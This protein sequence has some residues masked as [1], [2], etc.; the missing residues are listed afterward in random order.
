MGLKSM[1]S[2]VLIGSLVGCVCALQAAPVVA[3]KKKGPAPKPPASSVDTTLLKRVPAGLEIVYC[4]RL[5]Y[6]DG[7]WYA[8]IGYY[9]TNEQDK[10]YFGNGKPDKSALYRYTV[11]TKQKKMIFDAQGGSV[12]DPTVH[13]DG[14]TILFSYRPAN[15]DYFNLYTIQSDGTGLKQITRGPWDDYEPCWLPDGDIVFVSTRCKR[16]VGCWFTQVGV[17][18]RCKPDGSKIVQLSASIEHDNTPAV[19][20]DGRILFMRWEYVDRSQVEYHALWTMNPDG[21]SVNVF[22]GNMHSWIVMID[23]QPIPGTQE[24]I[25]S[26]SPG[27]GRNEHRGVPTIVSPLQ[28]PDCLEAATKLSKSSNYHDPIPLSKDLFMMAIDR[29]IVVMDREGKECPLY[30][31]AESNVHEPRPLLPRPR[32]AVL[33]SRTADDVAAT[34][35]A[36][37]QFV[38]QN[39]YQ[40]RNMVGVKPGDIKKLLVLEVLP[41]TI[42]F[43]GGMDLTSASGSFNIERVLG[44]VPVEDDGSASFIVPA[45]RAL[46]FVALDKNDLSVKRMQSFCNVMP[47]ESFTCVGCHE[48]RNSA[49]EAKSTP[50]TLMALQRKPSRIAS[51]AGYPDVF[52][53]QRDIQP[54]LDRNCVRCHSPEK[55]AGKLDLSAG[56]F[57]GFACSYR[58]LLLRR[59]V[60]D[61]ENSVGNRA[62]RTIG[63]SAS[64]LLDYLGGKHKNVKASEKDWRTVWLW[65]ESGCLYAGSCAAIRNTTEQHYYGH[66]SSRAASGLYAVLGRRCASCHK[67][68]KEANVNGIPFNWG[69][70]RDK[71]A[72]KW[73]RKGGIHGRLTTTNDPAAL[74]D[75]MLLIN[76]T[77]PENSAVLRVPL[78]KAAGGT[79]GCG[80]AIFKDKND[81]D[82][83]KILAGI[84]EAHA[85]YAAQPAWG[86]KG[87]KPNK[88][89]IREMKRYGVLPQAF[90]LEK[91]PFDPFAVDQAYWRSLWPENNPTPQ[92]VSSK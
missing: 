12:R 52:D 70:R 84:K 92:S 33:A 45:G 65:I 22:Y 39:V 75:S 76:I 85:L 11:A 89:Y 34:G 16:W 7:H 25:A 86:M 79:E 78:A 68:T 28:G 26:F 62:P 5:P 83:Q 88:D 48:E 10:A 38:L 90:D 32:E 51:F 21:T 91:D 81:P 1:V 18:H 69:I 19:L 40:G 43:S 80:K 74:Y 46:F 50:V 13:Y 15:T 53:Y 44:T 8:N 14:K 20:P 24:I 64:P 77:H 71:E 47:G 9:S 27:H 67:N 30:I 35:K 63:S 60:M 56:V 55:R 17:L 2:I 58:A 57:Q 31:D 23:G 72:P 59:L 87:W 37:G 42:N 3:A 54:V 36:E 4:T 41:K 29:S 6:R 66:A 73:D 82:Y 49:A 61:G